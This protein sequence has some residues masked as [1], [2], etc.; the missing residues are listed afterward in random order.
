[1]V[2]LSTVMLSALQQMS[3][4][5]W[6]GQVVDR[7]EFD[8]AVTERSAKN[9]SPDTSESVDSYLDCHFASRKFGEHT[10]RRMLIER[11]EEGNREAKNAANCGRRQL[12]TDNR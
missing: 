3:Q 1:M 7:N 2:L 12:T 6:I 10:G 5:F 4:S 11:K 8:I 9:V